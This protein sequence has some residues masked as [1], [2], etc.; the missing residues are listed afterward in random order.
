[1]L[2]FKN[3][4]GLYLKID[5][6]LLHRYLGQ[7]FHLP[8][9]ITQLK[10][11]TYLE[12]DVWGDSIDL[13]IEVKQ[14]SKLKELVLSSGTYRCPNWLVDLPKLKALKLKSPIIANQFPVWIYDLSK[15]EEFIFTGIETGKMKQYDD[16]KLPAGISKMKHLRSLTLGWGGLGDLITQFPPNELCRMK[17]LEHV[18]L[19][20]SGSLQEQVKEEVR[21]CADSY[22]LKRW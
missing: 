15:L 11:L 3:L 2:E 10:N 17:K 6:K 12:L 20:Y 5:S 9:S 7:S 16:Y 1:M 18:M 4:E 14:F 8:E 21:K 22:I 13:P 19:Y